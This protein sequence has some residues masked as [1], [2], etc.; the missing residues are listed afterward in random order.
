MKESINWEENGWT[1][2]QEAD[3]EEH[4]LEISC[5]TENGVVVEV[6]IRHNDGEENKGTC[7][8]NGVNALPMTTKEFEKNFKKLEFGVRHERPIM[9]GK[10]FEH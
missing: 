7:T 8:K 1:L 9:D 5:R 6:R 10:A 4:K 3:A 2:V